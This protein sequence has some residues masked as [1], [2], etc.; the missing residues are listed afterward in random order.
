[1][2]EEKFIKELKVRKFDYS[3]PIT[4]INYG[5]DL[6][7]VSVNIAYVQD[8]SVTTTKITYWIRFGNSLNEYV[9]G[10]ILEGFQGPDAELATSKFAEILNFLNLKETIKEK[11]PR[12]KLERFQTIGKY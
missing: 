10:F 3:E 4:E 1:M 12:P 6:C 2:K 5:E 11:I 8:C 7:F 9:F